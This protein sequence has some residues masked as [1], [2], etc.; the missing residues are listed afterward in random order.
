M[1]QLLPTQTSSGDICTA[2]LKEC[3][4]LGVGQTPLAEDLI[5]AQAR[6]QWMLQQ[7]ERKRWLVYH[8]VNYLIVS[9]GLQSYTVGPG[10]QFDTG[11]AS[12]RPN[13]VE[14]AF[15]RQ[16]TQGSANNVDY[17]LS[18]LQ[19]YED[20]NRLRLKSLVSF[21]QYCFYDPAWPLGRA[22]FWPIPQASIYQLDLLMR[23]QLPTLMISQGTIFTLPFEYYGAMM[24][25]LAWRL[26]SKYRIPTFPGDP[27]PALARDGE[28]TL[29]G[30]N[31]AISELSMPVG[32]VRGGI[33]N[34]FSDE[35]Y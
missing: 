14:S 22:F 29:K 33:Y 21:P 12:A 32:L 24:Y 18:V 8:L 34:I 20:Y 30:A 19:S 27:L 23:E 35:S 13:R 11:M 9:T 31:T 25:G 2:A 17:P 26:R 10:G 5:D 15:V 28:A 7:W 3:G 16:V 4:Y 1:S 6:L